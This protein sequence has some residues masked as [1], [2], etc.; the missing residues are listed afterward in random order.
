M[1]MRVKKMNLDVVIE[2]TV[3]VSVV[4]EQSERVLVAKVLKLDQGL[5]TESLHNSLHELLWKSFVGISCENSVVS[6]Y[7]HYRVSK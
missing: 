4:L 1:I 5:L 3:F 7:G 6:R 2:G